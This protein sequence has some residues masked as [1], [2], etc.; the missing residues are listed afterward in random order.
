MDITLQ[1][2]GQDFIPKLKQAKIEQA[3]AESEKAQLYCKYLEQ[4]SVFT[5]RLTADAGQFSHSQDKNEFESNGVEVSFI[6]II[7]INFKF[8]IKKK[9]KEI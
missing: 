3:K 6:F 8:L 2:A 9:T 7:Q 5:W 4:V 1:E